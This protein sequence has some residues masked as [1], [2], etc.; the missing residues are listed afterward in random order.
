MIEKL[1]NLSK[2]TIIYGVGKSLVSIVPLILT[3]LF[4]SF[5]SQADF[6]ELAL[7]QTFIS[8]ISVL[9]LMGHDS[10]SGYY[11]YYYKKSKISDVVISTSF[12]NRFLISTFFGFLCFIF[13]Q[14]AFDYL[15]EIE[16]SYRLNLVIAFL[17]LFL[18][19]NNFFLDTL[20]LFHKAVTFVFFAIARSTL[21]LIFSVFF[22]YVYG[23][24]IEFV[25]FGHLFAELL[26][27]VFNIFI[28][29]KFIVNGWSYKLSKK[30][31]HYGIY[32]VPGSFA[33]W[34]IN[35]MDRYFI[36]QQLGAVELA[37]YA[38]AYKVVAIFQFASTVFQMAWGVFSLQI[39]HDKKAKDI[40]A[41]VLL[42][43]FVIYSILLI[44]LNFFKEDIILLFSSSDYLAASNV[45]PYLLVGVCM[46]AL[47]NNLAIGVILRKQTKWIAISAVVGFTA[48]LILNIILIPE[49]G[50][51]GA[52]IAT[53]SAYFVV[54]CLIYIASQRYYKIRYNYFY[55]SIIFSA[56]VFCLLG[57]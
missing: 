34:G 36:A 56:M 49:F 57:N 40:Y 10:S 45:V 50:L 35:S 51:K 15:F 55:L 41:N 28:N 18:N 38:I 3:P 6:G 42:L 24:D 11:F 27:F 7:I 14:K 1:K 53:M 33:F 4:T 9:T 47:F 54:T 21:Y 43:I 37:L 39:Q 30:I 13:G 29:R 16:I 17:V 2:E 20:R 23:K 31:L 22:V 32:I 46:M 12:Y 44:F 19:L 5:Y 52:A 8:L 25:V 26:I 48:N